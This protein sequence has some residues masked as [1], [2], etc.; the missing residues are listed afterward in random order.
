MNR[1]W[2]VSSISTVLGISAL[3]SC[4][5]LDGRE[6]E[7]RNCAAQTY[8]VIVRDST[9]TMVDTLQADSVHLEVIGAKIGS[10][11]KIA[12]LADC[13]AC[14]SS[15]EGSRLSS[16][17]AIRTGAGD[18]ITA[19]TN[20]LDPQVIDKVGIGSP[21][22]LILF[23]ATRLSR[24]RNNFAFEGRIDGRKHTASGSVWVPDSLGF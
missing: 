11:R 15:F 22:S 6:C 18:T 10:L 12:A 14:P 2:I 3:F 7:D 23:K 8:S 24:G 21:Y 17:R 1:S 4:V 9:W 20:L 13:E 5:D 16:D 19:G